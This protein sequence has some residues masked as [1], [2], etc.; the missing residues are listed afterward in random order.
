[1]LFDAVTGRPLGLRLVNHT[2][3]GASVILTRFD[4]F[5][6]VG[7]VLLPFAITFAYGDDQY[8]YRISEAT[9]DWLTDRAFRPGSG[10]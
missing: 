7:N 8:R 1:M 3:R 5:R 4:E 2:G 10:R 6:P 9:V